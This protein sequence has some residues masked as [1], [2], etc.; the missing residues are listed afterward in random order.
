MFSL[1]K[2]DISMKKSSEDLLICALIPH[3]RIPGTQGPSSEKPWRKS[4][5]PNGQDSLLVD[6]CSGSVTSQE[7]SWAGSEV[8]FKSFSGQDFF[9]G[10]QIIARERPHLACCLSSG[11]AFFLFFFFF[12]VGSPKQGAW[13]GECMA[14][15]ANTVN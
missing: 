15:S 12:N 7:V 1:I 13:P 6:R 8:K 4:L 11:L 14:Q 5:G 9:L 10:V 2:T 3:S